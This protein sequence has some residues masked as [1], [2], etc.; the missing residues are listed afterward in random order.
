[1]KRAPGFLSDMWHTLALSMTL[2]FSKENWATRFKGSDWLSPVVLE[3]SSPTMGEATYIDLRVS[4]QSQLRARKVRSAISGSIAYDIPN[5]SPSDLKLK[6]TSFD[7]VDAM[8]RIYPLPK[9]AQVVAIEFEDETSNAEVL[10]VDLDADAFVSKGGDDPGDVVI[11][12]RGE[13]TLAP[14]H[15]LVEMTARRDEWREKGEFEI[16]LPDIEVDLLDDSNFLLHRLE[17]YHG[18]EASG[19]RESDTPNRPAQWLDYLTVS[20]DELPGEVSKVIVRLVDGG[21]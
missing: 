17:A 2:E 6:L 21:A 11:C 5:V 19:S 12:I 4:D 1:M 13:A 15:R 20:V 14:Y 7:A 10:D 3:I 8:S 18:L 9:V 16:L